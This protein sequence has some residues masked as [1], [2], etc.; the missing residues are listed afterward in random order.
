MTS[1]IEQYTTKIT[2]LKLHNV[3]L[4]EQNWMDTESAIIIIK[5]SFVICLVTIGNIN[6]IMCCSVIC[7]TNKLCS[8]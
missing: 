6:S 3:F 5:A 4:S 2:W 8:E 1:L 7:H